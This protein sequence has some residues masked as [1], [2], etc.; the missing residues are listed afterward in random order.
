MKQKSDFTLVIVG[1]SGIITRINRKTYTGCLRALLGIRSD[2]PNI[3]EDAAEILI[4][5][6]NAMITVYHEMIEFME[7]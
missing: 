3:F 1:K 6:N 4:L 7:V 5:D 2:C